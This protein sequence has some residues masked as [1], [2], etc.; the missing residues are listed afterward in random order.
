MG[1]AAIAQGVGGGPE[2][3]DIP[4]WFKR[5]M[6]SVARQLKLFVPPLDEVLVELQVSRDELRRWHKEGWLSFDP[7]LE[8]ESGVDRQDEIGFLRDVIRSGLSDVQLRYLLNLLPKPFDYDPRRIAFSFSLG[9]IEGV[10]GPDSDQVIHDRLDLW[11][12]ELAEAGEVEVLQNFG[13]R[14]AK[15]VERAQGSMAEDAQEEG[16]T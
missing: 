1:E 16:E 7:N 6:S 5:P 13:K 2:M 12:K 15:L 8:E 3:K 14:I 4:S 9:W 10:E 11:L